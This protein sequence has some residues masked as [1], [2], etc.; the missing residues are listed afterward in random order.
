MQL[1]EWNPEVQDGRRQIKAEP[2]G[3]RSL[4]E[5]V[6]RWATTERRELRG[7]RQTQGMLQPWRRWRIAVPRS[8]HR[9]NGGLRASRG[10]AKRQWRRRQERVGGQAFVSL[11]PF[12]PELRNGSLPWAKL[13]NGSPPWA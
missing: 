7:W 9:I 2:E 6:D 13:W 4:A 10:A 11:R 12:W 8:S 5:P 1:E 3:Q